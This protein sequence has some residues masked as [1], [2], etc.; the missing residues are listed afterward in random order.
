MLQNIRGFNMDE[1]F[2]QQ[3]GFIY[4]ID[5]I[6][7]ILRKT[8]LFDSSRQ[9]NDAEHSWHLALMVIVLSEYS[10]VKLDLAKT[11]KMVL[12]HDIP[13]IYT[14][15]TIVYAKKSGLQLEDIESAKKIFGLLPDEQ[16]DEFVSLWT[17][18]EEKETAEAKFAAAID[19]LE[20]VMQ[21]YFTEA[22]VW[23][24]NNISHSRIIGVNAHIANGSEKLW[25]YA[26]TLIDE[27]VNKGLIK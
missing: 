23:K 8:K 27:C 19:R 25:E 17:E 2:K 11:V 6:K 15:D 3:I 12:I 4:E 5:R 26:K 16:R 1:R 18:F 22:Y 9:E 20:P 10:N 24:T 13:E 21:N 14:G 7:S